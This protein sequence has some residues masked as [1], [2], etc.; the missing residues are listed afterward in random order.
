VANIH[1]LVN[2]DAAMKKALTPIERC[3]S[4]YDYEKGVVRLT[5]WAK[6]L[7]IAWEE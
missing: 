2:G 5:A 1:R 4:S 6:S 7:G 3:V